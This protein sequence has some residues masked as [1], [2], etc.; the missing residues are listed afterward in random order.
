MKIYRKTNYSR[1]WV[2]ILRSFRKENTIYIDYTKTYP[3]TLIV[4]CG[5]NVEYRNTKKK[6]AKNFPKLQCEGLIDIISDG[7]FKTDPNILFGS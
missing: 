6:K 7:G 1:T 4:L 5:F 2:C 3:R